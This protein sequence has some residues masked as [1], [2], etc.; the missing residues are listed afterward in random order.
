MKLVLHNVRLSFPKIWTPE[1]FPGSLDKTEYFSAAFI[2]PPTHKQFDEI[3]K[4]IDVVGSAKFGIKWPVVKAAATPLGKLCFRDGATKPETEGYEGNWF[5]SARSK[6]KPNV[7]GLG[8]KAAGVILESSGKPYGGCYVSAVLSVFA[9]QNQ[10]KGVA[11]EL[12]DIQFTGEG[13]AFAGGG[14]A[15]AGDDDFGSLDTSGDLGSTD[16]LAA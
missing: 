8:G 6:V 7:Y 16:P 13:D 1:P 5:V 15:R 4:V 11:A 14:G 12:G 3:N 10:A 2:V 9:Y